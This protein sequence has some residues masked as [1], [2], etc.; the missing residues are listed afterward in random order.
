MLVT[1]TLNNVDWSI[2]R[3]LRYFLDASSHLYMRVRPS[4]RPSVSIKE[5]TPREDASDG[6]V[7]GLVY[8]L[9]VF[10][11]SFNYGKTRIFLSQLFSDILWTE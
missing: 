9:F 10:S 5:K 4:V 2:F 7:S 3:S 8:I 6:R 1:L 11:I